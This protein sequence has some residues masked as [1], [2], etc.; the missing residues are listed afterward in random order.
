MEG[1]SEAIMGALVTLDT[2]QFSDLTHS[3][4]SDSHLHQQRLFSLLRSPTHFSQTL[5]YLHTLS[6]PQ[7]TSLIARLLLRSL[8]KISLISV[9]KSGIPAAG[10]V[11]AGG[12]FRE[13]DG[14]L[15]LMTLCEV[16]DHD[17]RVSDSGGQEL[18]SPAEWHKRAT[19]HVLRN[20]LSPARFGF[21]GW[22]VLGPYVDAVAK[23]RRFI[24]VV[25]GGGGKGEV[26]VAASV[27]TV[28]SLPSVECGGF[29]LECAICKE[30]L[31][32]GRGAC[33][34]PCEHVFH[35]ICILPWLRNNNT[36]PCCRFELP[37][38]DVFCEVERLWRVLI[39]RAD[40][41]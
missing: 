23:Y 6:L 17:S 18:T 13:L 29:G 37:T 28:V 8:N 31:E 12:G 41:I 40:V 7:K 19:D 2:R 5:T 16:Y 10:S 39:R 4:A 11:V 34:L 38:D 20:T 27:A 32:E 36:C 33:E 1:S 24:E 35:W 22:A 21:S 14:A 30:E 15:L 9:P 3:I 26:K 25:T